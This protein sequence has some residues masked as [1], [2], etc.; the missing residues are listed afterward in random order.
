MSKKGWK[1]F[2]IANRPSSKG[3]DFLPRMTTLN[4]NPVAFTDI[5]F[6]HYKKDMILTS[7]MMLF[8]IGHI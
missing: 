2:F 7:D 1:K 8:F 3:R 5:P 6:D 4:E